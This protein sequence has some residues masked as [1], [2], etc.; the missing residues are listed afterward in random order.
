MLAKTLYVSVSTTL[1]LTS[2]LPPSSGAQSV[3]L[4]HETRRLLNA[5]YVYGQQR[6][7][8]DGG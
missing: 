8:Q 3:Y 4:Q 7:K 5:F 2:W 6:H 1:C